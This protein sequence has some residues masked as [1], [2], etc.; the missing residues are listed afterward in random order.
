VSGR[1]ILMA[2]QAKILLYG[3]AG[4]GKSYSTAT[5]LKL[6]NLRPHQRVIYLCTERNALDGLRRGLQAHKIELEVGQLIYCVAR[7]KKKKAFGNEVSALAKYVKQSA[8][9]SQ[10]SDSS[11]MGKDKYTFFLDILKGLENFTGIDYLTNEEVHIG[12]VGELEEDDILIIDGLSPIT[13]AIWQITK[14]DRVGGQ[15]GDYQVV[16]YW[17]KQFT[18]DLIELDCSVIMLAHADRI[19]DDIEK[20]EKIRISLEA[21]V[22]LAGKYA[23]GWSDVIYCYAKP[24][25]TRVWTG[26]KMGVETVARN[27]PESDS[28]VP[29]F[30]VYNFFR[31]DGIT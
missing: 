7:P 28:L 30:S 9:D 10:K 17:I 11:N 23:G 8:A 21:G 31:E 29:D 6:Q 15:I 14:G 22:A 5:L 13:H 18:Q 1:E 16:Q 25:G 20:V 26:R 19:Y 4:A 24:D 3:L 2:K 27:F 12:N